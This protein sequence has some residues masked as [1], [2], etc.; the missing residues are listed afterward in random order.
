[1]IL[2]TINP[3][4]HFSRAPNK[5]VASI[6]NVKVRDAVLAQSFSQP[7]LILQLQKSSTLFVII[8]PLELIM[9]R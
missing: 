9:M 5:F 4:T 7:N 6:I 3:C 1:M 8:L 2:S